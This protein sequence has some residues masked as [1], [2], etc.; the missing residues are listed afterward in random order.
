MIIKTSLLLFVSTLLANCIFAAQLATPTP[1]DHLAQKRPQR[2]AR[3]TATPN[4]VPAG[5]GQ[6]TARINWQTGDGSPGEVRVAVAGEPEKLFA[7]SPEGSQDAEWITNGSTCEFRLYSSKEPIALLASVEV[8]GSAEM[9]R[10]DALLAPLTLTRK[11][12]GSPRVVSF[13]LIMLLFAAIYCAK[14]VGHDRFAEALSVMVIVFALIFA[15]LSVF[16]V[17]PRSLADQPFPDAHELSDAARQLASGNGYVTYVYLNERHP[18]RS[19]PGFPLLLTPFVAFGG[20]FPASVQR[21][22]KFFAA[23]YVLA[24]VFAA[25]RIGGR[26]AAAIVAA[27]IGVSPFART[28]A[29]LILSDAFAAG[30]TVLFIPLLRRLSTRRVALCRTLAGALV[31]VRLPMVLNLAALLVV[32]PSWALRRYLAL[33]ASPFVAAL[34]LYNWVTFGS[35]LRT[36]YSYWMPELKNFAWSYAVALLPNRDG[37]WVV[38]D[39]LNGLLWQWMCPCSIGVAAGSAAQHSLFIRRYCLGRSGSSP[40]L[41][42][43]ARTCICL[44]AAPRDRRQVYALADDDKFDTLHFLLSSRHALDGRTRDA[45]I[46]LRRRRRSAAHRAKGFSHRSSMKKRLRHQLAYPLR[47]FCTQDDCARRRLGRLCDR[48]LVEHRRVQRSGC[49]PRDLVRH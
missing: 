10:G 28:Y 31:A 4:P 8:T 47:K 21:S 5:T 17:E 32:L 18:P 39:A 30:M 43:A 48:R 1:D 11:R 12:I 3:I 27:M 42:D 19:P 15:L 25:W 49:Q 44:D 20:E 14:R 24:A 36:G 23:L 45:T 35:P 16:T 26:F 34:G 37:P 33:S 9:P 29:S 38:A 22:A 41:R 2:F 46:D 6:G 7:R 13:V 40:H